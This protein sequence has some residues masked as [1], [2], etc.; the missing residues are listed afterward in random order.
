[1]REFVLLVGV[2]VREPDCARS[3]EN[4]TFPQGMGMVESEDF[5]VMPLTQ[6]N[7]MFTAPTSVLFHVNVTGEPEVGESVEAVNSVSG[8][9][10]VPTVSVTDFAPAVYSTPFASFG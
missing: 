6:G 2:S 5:Q 8:C 10:A 7:I 3:V 9:S 1:M 4:A